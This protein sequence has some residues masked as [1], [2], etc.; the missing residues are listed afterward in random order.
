MAII[1]GFLAMAA[2]MFVVI[3][4]TMVRQNFLMRRLELQPMDEASPPQTADAWAVAN[5]FAFLGNYTIKVGM[6]RTLMS[7]WQ[8]MDRPTF[9]CRYLV[10]ASG[11]IQKECFDF[12]TIFADKV[13]LT[14]GSTT[15]GHFF[16]KRCGS[17]MQSFSN[18]DID[19]RWAAHIEAENYLMDNLSAQLV[20]QDLPFEQTFA[21][22]VRMECEYVSSLPLW[23]FCG[24]WWFLVRRHRW[25]NVSVPDQHRRGWIH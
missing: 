4:V 20:Q 11:Q 21:E 25:H 18:R 16:P 24:P 14:T 15:D 13:G 1:Y 23:F 10:Q 9:F 7:A 3:N 22:A 2:I 19:Q 8:R 12:V 5:G 6:I 17:Y